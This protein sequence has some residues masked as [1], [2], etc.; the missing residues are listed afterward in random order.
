VILGKGQT[1]EVLRRYFLATLLVFYDVYFD[2][3][4]AQI[5][6]SGQRDVNPWVGWMDGWMDG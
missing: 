2:F 4:S 6:P 3:E 1:R 5:Q